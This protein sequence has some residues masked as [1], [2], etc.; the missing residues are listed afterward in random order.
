MNSQEYMPLNT[1]L[2]NADM[3]YVDGRA[4]WLQIAGIGGGCI[5]VW[6]SLEQIMKTLVFQDR[7]KKGVFSGENA[8]DTYEKFNDWGRNIGHGLAANVN[9]LQECFPNIFSERDLI[10]LEKVHEYFDRRYVVNTST[11]I[12]INMLGDIDRVY[13]MLRDLVDNNIPIAY[14]DEIA[15]G[16]EENKEHLLEKY[17]QLAYLRNKSFRRRKEYRT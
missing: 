12:S 16:R 8:N 4:L 1:W 14:I 3:L 6:L 11:G 10:V 9:A 13:F 17:R 5:L 15:L 7:I 2:T